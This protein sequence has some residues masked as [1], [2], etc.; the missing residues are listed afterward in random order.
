MPNPQTSNSVLR[1]DAKLHSV[2][3]GK[4]LKTGPDDTSA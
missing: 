2:S 3:G 1:V 4:G